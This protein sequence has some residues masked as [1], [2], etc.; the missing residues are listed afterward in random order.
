MK[1]PFVVHGGK[2]TGSVAVEAALTLM[3]Q[4]Y[5]L[6]EDPDRMIGPRATVVVVFPPHEGE[7]G[8]LPC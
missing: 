1:R 8:A 7:G 6:E 5:R 2:G 3:E 4:S